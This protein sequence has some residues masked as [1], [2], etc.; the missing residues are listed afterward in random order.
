M[1]HR[2]ALTDHLRQ[3]IINGELLP[4]SRLSE[5]ALANQMD[6]SRN[7]L[8]ET[9]RALT[10]Q[11][12]LGHVP[13]RGVS[14]KAPTEADVLDIYRCRRTVECSV[15]GQA[16]PQH[17]AVERML[18][19]V[20]DAESHV[21]DR[22]WLGMG[23]ANMAFHEAIVALSDSPRLI[24][25]FRNVTAELRLVFLMIEDPGALHEP[26]VKSNREILEA[27]LSDGPEA[28]AD[29]LEQYLLESERWVL[30]AYGRRRI[31]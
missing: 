5:S 20:Q 1:T 3:K 17:P 21:I 13:Y 2:D 15:M 9:F 4:G 16:H 30:G 28:G 23:S 8:R 12:L 25:M 24:R 29:A 27:L 6:V 31:D 18:R 19:A 11:G 7:T 14:V 26:F 22:N 10:E